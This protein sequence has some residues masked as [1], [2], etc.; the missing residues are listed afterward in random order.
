MKMKIPTWQ[1]ESDVKEILTFLIAVAKA[2][3]EEAEKGENRK[4]GKC[5]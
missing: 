3:Q 5:L 1:N 4:N 2:E